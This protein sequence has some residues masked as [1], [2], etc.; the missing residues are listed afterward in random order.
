MRVLIIVTTILIAVSLVGC[1]VLPLESN[2]EKP[3]AMTKMSD[4]GG[5]DFVV[6][7]QALWLF[8]GAAPIAETHNEKG[9]S[10]KL[11]DGNNRFIAQKSNHP[12]Q[13]IDR[14]KEIAGGQKPFAIIL[15]CSDSRVPP[16]IIFDQGLGDL[17]VIRVAGNVLDETVLASAE[18]AVEHL[19]IP[20]LM[21]LGHSK[22]GAVSAAVSGHEYSG[23]IRELVKIIAPAVEK[24]QKMEGDLTE[25]AIK[26][27]IEMVS[28]KLLEE[29]PIIH[30]FV[31][32]GKLE[33]IGAFYDLES[34]K[35]DIQKSTKME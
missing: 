31:Y 12:N 24:A 21:V 17:F 14:R 29:S 32:S 6:A 22:C 26:T 23:H 13:T 27:N 1:S 9:A 28:A 20:F 7:N 3:V 2:L 5:T 25:N 30:E 11:I 10:G 15:S 19:G 35:V 4:S 33:I 18:Y 16:E 8:W 34:G